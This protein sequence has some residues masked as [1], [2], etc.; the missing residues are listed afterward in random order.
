MDE[1]TY[2]QIKR[3]AEL[4]KMG[5]LVA[6]P[7]ETVY[8]LGANAFDENAVRKI[9]EIKG[10]PMDNPLI[11]HIASKDDVYVVCSKVPDATLTLIERFWPGPLTLVLPKNPAVP[12]IV[13]AGLPTVA[14]RMPSHPI[15]LKLIELADVPIAAPS[16][17]IAGKP[18]A[19]K[20]EHIKLYFG[21][22]VF[23]IEGEVEFGIESTVIDLTETPPLLLRPGPIEPEKLKEILGEI[24]YAE[25]SEKPKS[26]GLK[27]KHYKPSSFLILLTKKESLRDLKIPRG[28][29]K[30]LFVLTIDESLKDEAREALKEFRVDFVFA[31]KDFREIAKNLFDIL[32]RG[33]K[34]DILIFQGVEEKGIGLGIMNRLKKAADIII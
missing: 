33:E 7:T 12:D 32:I 16:V 20:P 14:V 5:E 2:E 31:G 11:V 18:S 15:A 30:I 6:F 13:S 8:G 27:Y 22:K 28:E 23:V 1:K 19:T 26:P 25:K 3:G 10:R 4:I 9:F 29:K 34:Y 24:R 17:N 21:D